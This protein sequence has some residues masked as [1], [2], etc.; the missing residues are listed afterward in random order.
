M[1]GIPHLNTTIGRDLLDSKYDALRASFVMFHYPTMPRIGMISKGF[2]LAMDA[3]GTNVSL[4]DY[5]SGTPREDVSGKH[6][7]RAKLMSKLARGIHETSKYML[8][9]NKPRT[10][11]GQ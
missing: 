11:S 7:G 2:Y 4:H 8:Y 1:A 10:P 3:D 6:P 5:N 9:N